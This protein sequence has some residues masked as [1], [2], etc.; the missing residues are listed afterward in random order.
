MKKTGPLSFLVW[1]W[2]RQ[3]FLPKRRQSGYGKAAAA[4][5][6]DRPDRGGRAQMALPHAIPAIA[7][8]AKCICARPPRSGLSDA[9]AAA[10]FPYPDCRPFGQ[11]QLPEPEPKQETKAAR[12][13]HIFIFLWKIIHKN[14]SF[15]FNCNF[16][17]LCEVPVSCLRSNLRKNP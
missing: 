15:L 1:F 5:A 11:K 17:G 3:L 7:R 14:R 6:S 9:K 8:C 10:A 2:F 13:F 4:F 12:L 16:Y